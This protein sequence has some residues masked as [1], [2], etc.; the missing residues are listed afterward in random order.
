MVNR[1]KDVLDQAIAGLNIPASNILVTGATGF[2][3]SNVARALADAGH[4]VTAIGRNRYAAASNC[5]FTRVDLRNENQVLQACENQTVVIHSAA[6]SSP[7]R[8]YADLS[9]T[10]VQGTENVIN[11]C[12]QQNVKRLIHISSTSIFFEYKDAIDIDDSQPPAEKFACGYAQTKA[13]AEQLVLTAARNK[14]LNAFVIRARAIF[15]PGDNALVPRIL[16]AYDAGKLRQ[17][18]SGNNSTDLTHVDNLV[19]AIA[20]AIANGDQG[21]ICT[22]TGGPPVKVWKV[23]RDILIATGR[24]KPLR[25]IPYRV[26]NVAATTIEKLH[27]CFGLDE[28][29]LTRFSVGLLATSQTFT[30]TAAKKQ[31]GYEPILPMDQAIADTI[32]SLRQ[33]SHEHSPNVVDLKLFSTGFTTQRF[34][35]VEKGQS[36]KQR[37]P[38][39]ASIGVIE[40][41]I[42]GLTLFDTGHAP[43]FAQATARFPFSLYRRLTPATTFPDHSALKIIQRLGYEPGDV[44]RILLSH[45]HGDH[46]CGLRDFPDADIIA[47]RE[48]WQSVRR[49]KGMAAVRAAF[50]PATMPTDIEDRL[51]LIDRFHDPGMGPFT[52]AFDLFGDGSVRLIPL[53]GHAHG[54]LGALLQTGDSDR[55]LLVADAV[56]TAPSITAPLELTLPFKMIAASSTAARKTHRR[57]SELHQQFP[58]I[59]IL[60]THCRF[61]AEEHGFDEALGIARASSQ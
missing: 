30:P 21:G 56:W 12:L 27:R 15:G 44:K 35:V 5:N 33:I 61:V 8:T 45:F 39:H 50:L 47:T 51:H 16:E 9:P 60:P 40:H 23:V 20:L 37:I 13:E 19:Y 49:K 26:A 34:G 29:K 36:Y 18:G 48:A 55:S 42:H 10:N 58:E 32:D 59:K 11:A 7:Y 53:P 46:T 28:P 14:N 41:P 57:L 2:V 54:Q 43:R 31:L 52:N 3:G 4:T 24:N 38:I 6:E 22:V 25:S 17:I 1:T